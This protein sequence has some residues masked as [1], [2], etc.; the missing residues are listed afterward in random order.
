MKANPPMNAFT[1]SIVRAQEHW[2]NRATQRERETKPAFT[3]ALE[4]EAGA[5]GTTIAHT[6]GAR[7][8]W[9][10]YDQ[11][12]VERIAHD[13]GLRPALLGT[14]DERRKSWL[15]EVVE[16]FSTARGVTENA[17]VRH[18]VQTLLSLGAHGEC[19]I[20][21]R[22]A[23]LV[24]SHETTLR[25][26]L[27]AERHDRIE[28]TRRRLGLTRREAERWV[29]ETQRERVAFV[30]DHLQKDP[31]DPVHYDLVLNTSRWSVAECVEF[32]LAGLRRLE[33]RPV[34]AE[35]EAAAR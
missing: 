23:A 26:G 35:S 19:V 27:V 1:E 34:P 33:N 12:L 4:R 22:G 3:I 8:H 29:D 15:L 20:V 2:Y 7:L 24:L 11:E 18:L 32:I 5:Q 28:A 14:V 21:G 16:G 17:Y 25:V 10:V 13:L 30:R 6:L 9:S 31:H